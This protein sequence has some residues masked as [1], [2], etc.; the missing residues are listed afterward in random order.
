MQQVIEL[1]GSIASEAPPN[2]GTLT[3]ENPKE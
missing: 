2:S 3:V 1:R